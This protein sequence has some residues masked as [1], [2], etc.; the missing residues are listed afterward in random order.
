MGRKQLS[1]KVLGALLSIT[2]LGGGAAF[3]PLGEAFA[4]PSGAAA[5]HQNSAGWWYQR[6]D[7]SFPAGC[8][9][10]I[11]GKW[12][13]FDDSGYMLTGWYKVNGEWNWSDSSGVWHANAWRHDGFGWWY[14]WADGTYPTS[15]WQLIDGKWY[16]FD[17]SGYML[18]GWQQAGGTWYYLNAGGDMAIGWKSVGGSWYWLGESGAMA[19]GWKLI[20]SDWYH[21]DSSG[22]MDT[23]WLCLMGD[24]YYL[25]GDGA[26]RTGWQNLSG[27]WYYLEP[28]GAMATGWQDIGGARYYLSDS[29]AMATGTRTICGL[30]HRFASSGAWV[31]QVGAG[32]SVEVKVVDRVVHTNPWGVETAVTKY[33]YD[34]AGKII[35]ATTFYRERPSRTAGKDVFSYDGYKVTQVSSFV[36]TYPEYTSDPSESRLVEGVRESFSYDRR[37][38]CAG[39]KCEILYQG[40]GVET[41]EYVVGDNGAVQRAIAADYPLSID[42]EGPYDVRWSYSSDG[43]LESIV[44]NGPQWYKWKMGMELVPSLTSAERNLYSYRV[45]GGDETVTLKT[46][47]EG[48]LVNAEK[49]EEIY[50][51][52]YKSIL[53]NS[54]SYLPSIFS[55]PRPSYLWSYDSSWR[56]PSLTLSEIDRI[57]GRS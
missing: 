7:G 49:G 11:G 56:R 15:S 52:E 26:M 39:Y 27:T 47:G 24:W 8:W 48:N 43:V 13:R 22:A 54:D 1:C 23:G 36:D 30:T 29:G 10:S 38:F 42:D 33:E 25:S 19:T 12:Y 44:T 14:S 9:E 41:M 16:L 35:C 31:N 18:T 55:N 57:L 40:N 4:A 34:D 17:G 50:K 6:T 32:T 21:L 3:L 5:W 28:S 2:L 53:V 20:G 51:Y 46:D 37:G 45:F